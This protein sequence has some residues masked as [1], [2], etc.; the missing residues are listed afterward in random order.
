MLF[1]TD[2]LVWLLRGNARAARVVEDSV[3]AAVS[4]ITYMELLRGARDRKETRLVKAFL[5]DSGLVVMPLTENIGH[6]AAIYA[7]EYGSRT[8]IEV[9][10]ML[11]AATAVETGHKLCT[12]NRK[13]YAAIADLDIELFRP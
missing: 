1:D 3:E 8:S 10:D 13:H 11:I 6:R 5:A 4:I 12:G 2:V 7:E 9:A